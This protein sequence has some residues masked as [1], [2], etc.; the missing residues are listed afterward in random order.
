MKSISVLA[1]AKVNLDLRVTGKRPDGY[2][3]IWSIFQTISLFDRI[4]LTW[5]GSGR[6]LMYGLDLRP[7]GNLMT[8]A[9]TEMTAAT[10]RRVDFD[11][12]L[13]KRI[14]VAAGLGGGS[15]DAGAV[16]LALCRAWDLDPSSPLVQ[17]AAAN[18][19]SDVPFFLTGG[20]ALV[21][22]R[23]DQV[24][25][26]LHAE[27]GWI[28]LATPALEL[29]QKT[30]RLYA[31]LKPADFTAARAD[32]GGETSHNQSNAFLR[33]LLELSPEFADTY[34][35]MVNLIEAPIRLS[36][37]GPTLFASFPTLSDAAHAARSVRSA[38]LP[39]RQLH[40]ARPIRGPLPTMESETNIFSEAFSG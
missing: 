24:A 9:A 2:H 39:L 29:E 3:D 28:L 6:L 36:G 32:F 4:E 33:P 31:L 17:T 30:G 10:G 34:A 25:P 20:R 13:E 8:R 1:P 15:A 26:L 14:P 5:P 23:G 22:G 19:G 37:A 21:T 40:I 12:S 11:M 18:V 16:I 27:A 38:D 7:E 35:R